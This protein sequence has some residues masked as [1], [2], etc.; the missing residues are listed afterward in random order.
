MLSPDVTPASDA[1]QAEGDTSYFSEAQ[2][3]RGTQA[4]PAVDFI[5]VHL[6]VQ[7]WGAYAPSYDETSF[8]KSTL[9]WA[10]AYLTA[11]VAEA[12]SLGKPVVLEEFGF[13]RDLG[14]LAPSAPT[15]RR[16][17]Y[18]RT[19]FEGLLA[20]AASQGALAG[21]NFWA[22]AGEGRPAARGVPGPKPEL[23]TG[24]AVPSGAASLSL[25]GAQPHWASC[26]INQ[27][28]R[29]AACSADS[30]WATRSAWPEGSYLGQDAWL[31]DPPH[32]SQGWYSVFNNDTTMAFVKQT[33][34]QL[35]ATQLCAAAAVRPGGQGASSCTAGVPPGRSGNLC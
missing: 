13:P 16:D 3:V 2:S 27:E 12:A 28:Q 29:P 6:W 17:V 18:Y 34:E 7:N 4:S 21:V 11:S 20:S 15:L 8:E 14:S 23:C 22:Y 19:I 9:P 25:T 5:T 10:R 24:A 35:A 30:W 32:E 33:G 1:R 31:G 26:F